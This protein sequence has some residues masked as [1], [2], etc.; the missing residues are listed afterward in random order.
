MILIAFKKKFV[1]I[2]NCDYNYNDEWNYDFFLNINNFLSLLSIKIENKLFDNLKKFSLNFFVTNPWLSLDTIIF[3]SH[4]SHFMIDKSNL[5]ANQTLNS[6][7]FCFDLNISSDKTNLKLFVTIYLN[8]Y[9]LS[10][11]V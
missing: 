11:K 2:T 10:F 4:F 8:H 1:D 5:K 9:L 7:K 3:W 6:Q